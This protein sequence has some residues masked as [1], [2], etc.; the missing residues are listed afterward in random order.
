MW[1]DLLHA[2]LFNEQRLLLQQIPHF[3]E[4]PPN[5]KVPMTYCISIDN[6]Q[7]LVEVD[8]LGSINLPEAIHFYREMFR[9]VQENSCE[10]I[11]IDHS[12]SLLNITVSEMYSIPDIWKE[13]GGSRRLKYALIAPSNSSLSNFRFLETVA[14]NRGYNLL[15]FSDRQKS[16]EW[17]Q[18]A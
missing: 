5:W 9:E 18:D 12:R 13:M 16:M 2:V 15:I 14:R 11:L 6:I 7:G 3:Y 10:R 4:P 8:I 1:G 17:L